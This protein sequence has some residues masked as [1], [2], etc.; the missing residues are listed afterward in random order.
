MNDRIGPV[1]ASSTQRTARLAVSMNGCERAAGGKS[2][3]EPGEFVFSP[4]DFDKSIRMKNDADIYPIY[5]VDLAS[6][7]HS[8]QRQRAER[9]SG[10]DMKPVEYVI[11]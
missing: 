6:L 5:T 1:I 9:E 3:T 10:Q 7:L 4:V 8:M 2:A 11:Y